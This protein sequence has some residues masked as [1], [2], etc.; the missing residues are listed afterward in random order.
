MLANIMT[1]QVFLE[2]F[3]ELRIRFLCNCL[4]YV[5]SRLLFVI[6]TLCWELTMSVGNDGT[7][8]HFMQSGVQDYIENCLLLLCQY[9]SSKRVWSSCY[10]FLDLMHQAAGKQEVWAHGLDGIALFT[11]LKYAVANILQYV[12]WSSWSG[13][14]EGFGEGGTWWSVFWPFEHTEAIRQWFW[15]T[16]LSLLQLKCFYSHCRYVDYCFLSSVTSLFLDA[17][18]LLLWKEEASCHLYDNTCLISSSKEAQ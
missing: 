16:P 5:L 9:W 10:R 7:Q 2:P 8:E 18:F 11:L 15:A 12:W 17:C 1:N 4:L 3:L 6:C 13:L 14:V